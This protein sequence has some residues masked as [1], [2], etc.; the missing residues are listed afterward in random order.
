MIYQTFDEASKNLT[1]SE[2]Q[3]ILT[4]RF[5]KQFDP[6]ANSFQLAVWTQQWGLE[7]YIEDRNDFHGW[8]SERQFFL[9]SF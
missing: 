7:R 3:A 1:S 6:I 9:G 4:F 5:W 2:T 8:A